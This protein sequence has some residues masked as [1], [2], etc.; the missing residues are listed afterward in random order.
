MQI[1][2]YSAHK[3]LTLHVQYCKLQHNYSPI[4]LLLSQLSSNNTTLHN[5]TT[6]FT[7][8]PHEASNLDKFKFFIVSIASKQKTCS[9][10]NHWNM[11]L[12]I[13]TGYQR[14]TQK[15]YT[16]HLTTTCKAFIYCV[17]SRHTEMLHK[18]P[19]HDLYR[20]V[21]NIRRT[22]SPNLNVSRLALLL[23]L[24]NPLKPGVK[25]RMKM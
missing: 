18:T 20:K 3:G 12:S 7:R 8:W 24:P 5:Q 17:P 19:R 25:L 11:K 4:S 2:T 14:G 22:K 9:Q 23:S 13:D 16:K 6:R 21:S 1:F 10:W 15:C